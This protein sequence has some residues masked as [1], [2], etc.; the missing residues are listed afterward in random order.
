MNIDP[1]L[2]SYSR[3]RTFNREV[4]PLLHINKLE[5]V[6]FINNKFIRNKIYLSKERKKK[7]N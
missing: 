2:I 7:K 4:F 3:N 6:N 5:H 1:L